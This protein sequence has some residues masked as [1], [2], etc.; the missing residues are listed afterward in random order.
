MRRQLGTEQTK[1]TPLPGG[2][3][4]FFFNQSPKADIVPAN[5]PRFHF[6]DKNLQASVEAEA[7]ARATRLRAQAQAEA[8]KKAK[9]LENQSYGNQAM[10]KGQLQA[11][12]RATRRAAV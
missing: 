8:T 2:L 4:E 11:G 9:V 5:D 7:K 3:E 1:H 12:L 10:V 6:I